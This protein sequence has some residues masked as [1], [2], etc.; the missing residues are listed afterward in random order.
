MFYPQ[1]HVSGLNL[2]VFPLFNKN[3]ESVQQLSQLHPLHIPALTTCCQNEHD[4]FFL[5]LLYS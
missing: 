2:Y 1:M 5:Y 4:L 3:E